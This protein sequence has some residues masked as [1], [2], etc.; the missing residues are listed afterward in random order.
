M[1]QRLFIV[2]LL[3]FSSGLPLALTSS[4]LQAWFADAGMSVLATGM[5]SLVGLP[6]AYRVSWGPVL[7]RYSLLP[8]GKRR[9]WILIMQIALLMGFNALAWLSPNKAPELMAIL[10]VALACFS[11]TQDAA[12]DAHRVEYL[13]TEVHGL[14][15]SLASLGYRLALVVAGGFALVLAKHIGW[16]YTYRLM[17]ILMLIGVIATLWS[18]EPDK[19]FESK[20]SLREA[21]VAPMKDLFTRRGIIPLL[22]FILFYKLGEAF[23]TTT[24][25][26]V[27]PFLIQGLGF[28]LDTIGYVNKIMGISS[29]LL[30]GVVAGLL[31][32]RWSLFKALFVFG[33]L[34]AVTN[35]LFIL[36]AI[37]GKNLPLFA[38]AV[39][40][41]NF[42][43]GMGSTALVA[44][45]M[46]LVKQPYTATQFSLFVAISA[47]PR[48]FSG[49]FAAML[50]MS[51]GWIGLYQLS[52][53][54]ALG[55]IP[56]LMMIRQQT[57]AEKDHYDRVQA[58]SLT[59]T[60]S[61]SY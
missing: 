34:Q 37:V 45:L 55:F 33:I 46:R 15:A 24:S 54:I 22:F 17:G 25:G 7:D 48:I 9:S 42:A 58:G 32:M 27:M 1:N 18:R 12:I 36:L 4:T 13:P 14:G 26:I 60:D 51:F 41:D 16:A 19:P 50:Q 29:I 20:L 44:F 6:Y 5:L 43:A 61:G 31:L 59:P 57:M 56:F 28:S 10:A 52:F 8:L 3:G 11:A 53:I 30:G 23:T 49:P 35:S 2:F 39:V 21:F 38:G 40:C 47:L